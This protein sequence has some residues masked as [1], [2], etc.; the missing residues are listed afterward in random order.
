MNIQ[1]INESAF[2]EYSKNVSQDDLDFI[3]LVILRFKENS[4]NEYYVVLILIYWFFFFDALS[5]DSHLIDEIDRENI[6]KILKTFRADVEWDF[7]TYIFEMLGYDNDLFLVKII[8]KYTLLNGDWKWLALLS[9]WKLENYFKSIWYLIPV[10]TYK[11]SSF[12]AFFQDYY[13]KKLYAE[14]Y[15]KVRNKFLK[16][17][18]KLE[19]P[20]LYIINK[21]NNLSNL[22]KTIWVYWII[23]IRKKSYFSLYGKYHRKQDKKVHDYIWMRI[24][25]N[26]IWALNKFKSAFELGHIFL[27]KKDYIKNPKENWY[28]AIHYKYVTAFRTS[29][30]LVEL[31]IK[32]M[33]MEKEVENSKTLSHF[34]YTV[35]KNKWDPLFVE[36]HKWYEIME[37]YLKINKN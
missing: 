13:F 16:E 4:S 7:K 34:T 25:F 10:L 9:V 37:E 6:F 31:Q 36:V 33:K 24:V 23:T 18:S 12:L 29:Q 32:T 11:E 27:D 26:S 8:I 21:I 22:M 5:L 15:E 1:N 2:N 17:T 30:I 19:L 3:K 20:W 28:K 14:E 35:K